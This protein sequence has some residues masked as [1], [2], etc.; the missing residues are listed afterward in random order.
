MFI[1]PDVSFHAASTMKVCVLAELFRQAAAGE[2]SLTDRIEVVN[3]FKSIVDGSP[4]STTP[5]DDSEKSLYS[6]I[7]KRE[8]LIRLAR[9]MITES[10]NFATNL[11]I[12]RLGAGR[13]NATMQEL[14]ADGIS[15]LRGV[16][17][18]KAYRLGL[19]S[20]VTARGMTTL[21]TKIAR[22]EVVSAD[23]SERIVGIM[24]AQTHRRAIPAGVPSRTRVANKPGW[25]DG[26]CHDVGIVYP[27][28]RSPYVLCVMT[29]GAKDHRA[30]IELIAAISAVAFKHRP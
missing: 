15:V 29:R 16:E 20:T 11:L 19:N 12:A 28:R 5:E 1:Q 18:G 4:F 8:S 21:L 24:A 3:E 7:G 27:R 10:S 23:A 9:P 30:A 25:N 2:V 26:I 13:V 14:G 6:K 17:D 22:G